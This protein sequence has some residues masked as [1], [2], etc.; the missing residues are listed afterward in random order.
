MCVYMRLFF[1]GPVCFSAKLKFLEHRQQRISEVRAKYDNLS[2]E[3]KR[4]KHNL[5]LE[6]GKW[7]QECQ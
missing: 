6:P 4:A 1:Q 3:L 7:N 2:R 5:T